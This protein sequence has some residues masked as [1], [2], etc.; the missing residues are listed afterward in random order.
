[1][2]AMK[3]PYELLVRWDQN[4]T[5][6]GAHMQWATVVSDD[7]GAVIGCYPGNVEPV[8]IAPSQPGFPLTDILSQVQADA[9]TALT[10]AQQRCDALTE[11]LNDTNAQIAA[12]Q[13]KADSRNRVPPE[14][15]AT[16]T[17]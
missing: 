8:A 14:P 2:G 12:L 16:G 15:L 1:M 5:L 7:A 4:G 17:N 6:H 11:Q 9:L 10:T 3:K 13:V